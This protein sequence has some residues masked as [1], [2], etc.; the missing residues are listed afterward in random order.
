VKRRNRGYFR[1][2][3]LLA[4]LAWMGVLLAQQAPSDPW[5]SGE[6]LEP[7]QLAKAIESG[8]PPVILSAAFPVLYR[9][10]H[11]VH[12]INAGP[13]SKPEGI[14]ALRSAVAQLPKDADLVIYCG[15]CPLVKCPNI[16]PAYQTLKELGFRHIR[17]LNLADNLHQDWVSKGYPS[18]G[19]GSN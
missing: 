12:A 11:I 10:K 4:T 1:E 19:A 5:T 16:R 8:H 17:V 7:S 14:A 18:D 3:V 6:L 2:R 9:G 13:T 15:C